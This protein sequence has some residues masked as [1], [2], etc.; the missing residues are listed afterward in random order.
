MWILHLIKMWEILAFPSW[1]A[2]YISTCHTFFRHMH[3][4][5][6]WVN[7]MFKCQ[8]QPLMFCAAWICTYRL[9][10]Y[11]SVHT[12]GLFDGLVW[13]LRVKSILASSGVHY[14]HHISLCLLSLLDVLKIFLSLAYY[15]NTLRELFPSTGMIQTSTASHMTC[16]NDHYL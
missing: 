1:V 11:L 3:I 7:Y 4:L 13:H 10:N 2:L 8:G 14:I 16:E 12:T 6:I 5:G 15:R 9:R